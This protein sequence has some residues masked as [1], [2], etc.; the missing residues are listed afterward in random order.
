VGRLWRTV[1]YLKPV[2]IY[3]RAWKAVRPAWLPRRAAPPVRSRC[4]A[5][6]ASIPL[7]PRMLGPSRF[8][9]L[10]SV[11]DINDVG[12]DA[13]R[14]PRLWRYHLHYFDDLA[15]RDANS[16]AG[17][18]A[19]LIQRWIRE[20]PVGVGTGWE[21]YPTSRRIVNW[22]KWVWAGNPA[23]PAAIQSLAEQARWLYGR[24]EWH[25]LGNHLLA[26]AKALVFAGSF[27]SG[28]EADA[29]LDRGLVTLQAQLV[30]Q[31]LP[32][33]G[34]FE[35]SAMYHAVVLE[36]LLDVANLFN[37]VAIRATAEWP[38]WLEEVIQRME[39]FLSGMVHPD[40]DIAF[41]NDA[42]IDG[43]PAAAE[44]CAYRSR[45]GFKPGQPMEAETTAFRDTGYVRVQTGALVAL[46]DIGPVGPDY[47][48]GHAHADTLSFELSVA[49]R[50]VL[51]NSGTSEYTRGERRQRERGTAAHNTVTLGGRDSSEVWAA[52]RVGRRARPFRQEITHTHQGCRVSCC[53]DGY[54]WLPGQ[55]THSRTWQFSER[56]VEISDALPGNEPIE[57]HWHFHPQCDV[58]LDGDSLHCT[59]DGA[60]VLTLR[61]SGAA[62]RIYS[63]EYAPMFGVRQPNTSAQALWTG[64]RSA[65]RIEIDPGQSAK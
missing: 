3:G 54:S 7:P 28:P 45:L 51:V 55:P 53:H 19:D 20:N 35:R 43:A 26:N 18:H 38:G 49:G 64:P 15:A 50:R 62:W 11:H 65:V 25:L 46:L 14:L 32:D 48:P 36:D 52:F 13:P 34:H 41:F 5:W 63:S 40:G 56:G 21:P 59:I 37:G 33:G 60:P 42:A 58:R 30:E 23:S 9:F 1:R 22:I 10:H 24:M 6:T 8:E 44:L 12:W 27:F 17:W 4:T 31:I 47:L 39:T 57:S 29:W 61:V 2:Q 16:R